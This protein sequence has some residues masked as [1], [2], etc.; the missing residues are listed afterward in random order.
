MEV[1]L[2]AFYVR[3]TYYDLVKRLLGIQHVSPLVFLPGS[4]HNLLSLAF[5]APS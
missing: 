3:G 5:F 2:A 1:N 4:F